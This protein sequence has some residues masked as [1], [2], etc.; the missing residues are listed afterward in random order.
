MYQTLTQS[1]FHVHPP[2]LCLTEL[3]WIKQAES[4]LAGT[5]GTEPRHT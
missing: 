3:S 1:K 4:A 5:W 2:E